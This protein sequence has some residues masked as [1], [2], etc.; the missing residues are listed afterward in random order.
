MGHPACSCI[1]QVVV[2]FWWFCLAA[3]FTCVKPCT[4]FLWK[5]I[6]NYNNLPICKSINTNNCMHLPYYMALTES[7]KHCVGSCNQVEY[8]GHVS[9]WYYTE[10]VSENTALWNLVFS[11]KNIATEKES[12]GIHAIPTNMFYFS[13]WYFCLEQFLAFWKS[14]DRLAEVWV[15][16]LDFPSMA[17]WIYWN[18]SYWN[19]TIS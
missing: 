4:P 8:N 16:L 18:T 19:C 15:C 13:F 2:T 6:T 12:L 14:L 5:E 10:N 3:D 7:F 1:N 11:S 9:K 17:R